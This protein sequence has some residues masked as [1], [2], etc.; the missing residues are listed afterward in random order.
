[1]KHRITLVAGTAAATASLLCAASAAGAATAGGRTAG[2]GSTTP[3]EVRVN[4]VGYPPDS[5][6]VA[7]AMLPGTVRQVRFTVSGSMA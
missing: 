4:E 3:A 7:Y 5:A 6:K 2:S 1:M